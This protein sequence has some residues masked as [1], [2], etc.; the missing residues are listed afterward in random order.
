M[1]R[2]RKDWKIDDRVVVIFDGEPYAGTIVKLFKKEAKIAFDD[3][4]I[5]NVEY[6]LLTSEEEKDFSPGG[7]SQ[8]NVKWDASG[9]NYKFEAGDGEFYGWWRKTKFKGNLTG[10]AIDMH[11]KY[12][13]KTCFVDSL[14]YLGKDPK[15]NMASLNADICAAANK[16]FYYQCSSTFETIEQLRQRA[17]KPTIYINQLETIDKILLKLREYRDTA[18]RSGGRRTL[19]LEGDE[20]ES[21]QSPEGGM[22]IQLDLSVQAA[23][24]KGRVPSLM[25]GVI[26]DKVA[27]D[28]GRKIKG[29][30]RQVTV[31]ADPENVKAL[32]KQLDK[33]RN[34]D[35]KQARKLRA[36]LRRMG[37]RG[38]SRKK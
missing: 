35:P 11:V 5:L 13:D 36:A 37:H 33:C 10:Y 34:K 25:D 9:I 18:I 12:K 23:A 30:G 16:W 1:A 38:G 15:E 4:D 31:Q 32:L 6:K 22:R 21:S 3:T 29:R 26:L 28:P 17:A 7:F 14:S 27:E 2:K 19:I 24:L 20:S 8:Y